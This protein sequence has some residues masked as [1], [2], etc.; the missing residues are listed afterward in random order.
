MKI[1]EKKLFPIKI[2]PVCEKCNVQLNGEG[3]HKYGY[4]Y[5]CPNCNKEEKSDIYYPYIKYLGEEE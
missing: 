3:R 5:K 1:L 2:Y 4:L